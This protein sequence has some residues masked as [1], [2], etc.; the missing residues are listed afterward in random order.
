[1]AGVDC[2]EKSKRFRSTQLAEN[3]AIGPHAQRCH[4]QVL[5]PDFGLAKHAA[6]GEQADRVAVS[7]LELGGVLDQDQSFA[8]GNLA[9]QGIEKGRLAGRGAAGDQQVA[10]GPD[11]LTQCLAHVLRRDRDELPLAVEVDWRGIGELEGAGRFVVVD[12]RARGDMTADRQYMAAARGGGS[13]D[14]DARAAGQAR[15]EQ[16]MLATDALR[17]GSRDLAR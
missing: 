11:G 9:Q 17:A 6:R 14:L 16:R 8:G 13:D 7:Q 15:G 5:R 12:R 4:Q 10:P 2:A 1:V 3:D